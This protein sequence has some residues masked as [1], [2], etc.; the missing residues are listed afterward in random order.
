MPIPD[1]VTPITVM[2]GVDGRLRA[3]WRIAA[4]LFLFV[5]A[6]VATTL[7]L[8]AIVGRSP[9]DAAVASTLRGVVVAIVAT[10]V[11]A[12]VA[13]SWTGGRSG[14]LDSSAGACHT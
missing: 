14:L 12:I 5:L 9:R 13:G 10:I 7:V 11:V 4:F 1:H 3:G 6:S 2:R 8:R